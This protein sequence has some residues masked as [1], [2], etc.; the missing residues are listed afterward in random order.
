MSF[1]HAGPVFPCKDLVRG[2][3]RYIHLFLPAGKLVGCNPCW[4]SA[5][6]AHLFWPLDRER[7]FA[8]SQ[9]R[10]Y[11][12]PPFNYSFLLFHQLLPMMDKWGR[13][14]QEGSK[15]IFRIRQQNYQQF[16]PALQDGS[17]GHNTKSFCSRF[18][19][20]TQ[21]LASDEHHS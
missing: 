4:R 10:S 21:R 11:A 19:I 12:S 13:K 17:L 14:T 5:I 20:F 3:K 9:T 18:L 1:V 8:C 6:L 2:Q 16:H 7:P 15:W